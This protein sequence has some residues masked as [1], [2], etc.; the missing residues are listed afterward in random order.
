[1]NGGVKSGREGLD[2]HNPGYQPEEV[3]DDT[4]DKRT[5]HAYIYITPE[6]SPLPSP[7]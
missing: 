7:S 1:M 3:E 2:H 4:E 5:S 6:N